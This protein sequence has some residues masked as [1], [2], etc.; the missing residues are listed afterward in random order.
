MS[1]FTIDEITIPNTSDGPDA[2][3]Y[4]HAIETGNAVDAIGYGTTEL[5]YE[6][7]EELTWF[8]NEHLPRRMLGARVEGDIVARAVYETSIGDGADSAWLTVQVL[9][10][11]RGR[12][13]GTALADAV[14]SL[15]RADG[16]AKALVYTAIPEQSG[17]RLTPPTGVG[18]IP[19]DARDV[20]FLRS[21]GYSLEQVERFS[22][23][24]LPVADLEA[25]LAAAQE[26]SGGDYRV[27]TWIGRTPEEWVEDLALLGTRMSTDAPTAGLDEPED[28]WTADRIRAADDRNERLDPR[29]R[30]T[31]GAVH[32]P[33]GRLV[34]FTVLSVP[35]QS[36]RAVAQ[37]ATLVL[38]E[39]RGRALGMLVK[40]ANLEQLARVRPGHP[41]VTTFN[42]EENRHMLDVNEALGFVARGAESAWRKDLA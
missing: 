17:P 36:H 41:S 42:A 24:E 33:S 16:K 18:S 8:R 27:A 38:R 1:G 13:I 4:A 9:P 32:V 7:A 20:R 28:V 3:D 31:A 23:L 29:E 26:R 22:R 12:G 2:A 34:A 6:P 21:R 14:E 15:A 30:L 11:F 25:R 5:A 37:Y 10:A 40:V 19:A 39:H 35:R